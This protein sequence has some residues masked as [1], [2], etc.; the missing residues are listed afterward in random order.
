[1][2]YGNMELAISLPVGKQDVGQYAYIML[3]LVKKK[4]KKR[5]LA[6]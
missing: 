2:K 5:S 4:K 6:I 3:V 1:M